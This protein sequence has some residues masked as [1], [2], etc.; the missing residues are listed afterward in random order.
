MQEVVCY[1]CGRIV[2]VSP[3]AELCSVC[4]ENLREL[5]HPVYASKYFYDRAAKI[6]AGGQLTTALQEIDRG[7]RYQPSS[8]LRLLGAILS[9]RL[10]DHEQMRHHVAA[11]PVDDVLRPEGEW[12]LRSHQMRQRDLREASK[13]AKRGRSLEA[14]I[15]EMPLTLEQ[16]HPLTTTKTFVPPA[17]PG[18]LSQAGLVLILV[19][20]VG[21]SA[22]L[23]R[24]ATLLTALL[25]P[26]GETAIAPTPTDD[27]VAPV[28]RPTQ[29][30]AVDARAPTVEP[31][32]SITPTVTATPNVPNNNV[33]NNNVPNNV[34]QGGSA[35]TR[36]PE[37]LA[38]STTGEAISISAAQPFDLQSYLLT[39]D[40]T[41][42]A[43]LQVSADF[44][45]TIL[46][47]KGIVP[48]FADR[49]A[50]IT[51]AEAV[52]GATNVSAID[53]LLRL[54]DTY[55]VQPG[56]TL[57]DI[58]YRLYGDVKWIDDIV[59]AN[60][61][62]LPSAAYLAVGMRLKVPPIE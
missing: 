10:G 15:D 32:L 46:S 21:V 50:L 45:G 62:I 38:A 8:E 31:G 34:V 54:P 42:L 3:D 20:F 58:S 28:Y 17:K 5:L 47:L 33:P 22:L 18:L 26:T 27:L 41:E 60:R 30:E 16:V 37:A 14:V 23:L 39:L 4:G 61:E 48:T 24:N 51:L 36:L 13:G 7:L 25:G 53:L 56:D 1:N 55:T 49:Q 19:V 2:H 29:D 6:A 57:W 43:A 59:A 11:I 44:Q 40:Q 9:K 52:P 12:L 35:P